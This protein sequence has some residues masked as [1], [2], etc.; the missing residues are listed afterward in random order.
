MAYTELTV[1]LVAA[2]V[3]MLGAII[4]TAIYRRGW[5]EVMD[6]FLPDL[7]GQGVR[8]EIAALI[9]HPMFWIVSVA[10]VAFFTVSLLFSINLAS[11]GYEWLAFSFTVVIFFALF[12]PLVIWFSE[13]KYHEPLRFVFGAMSYGAVCALLAFFINSIAGIFLNAQFGE[14][15]GLLLLITAAPLIEEA[16]KMLGVVLISAHKSFKGPLDGLLVGFA[17]GTGFAMMEN[18]FYT[19]TKIPENSLELLMFRALYNTLAHGAFTAIGG[20]VLGKIKQ[21]FK[22]PAAVQLG[23][24]FLVAALTHTAFNILAIVDIIGV[25]SLVLQYYIFSPLMVFAL[26]LIIA[27]LI[28]YNWVD[29]RRRI[30]REL[31]SLGVSPDFDKELEKLRESMNKKTKK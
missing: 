7:H 8:G 11:V 13:G 31:E 26:M 1:W 4:Y 27:L 23:V 9:I 3:V 28:F 19:A 12:D 6:L 2:M 30:A 15:M 22:V 29:K 16:L 5:L 14:K 18:I 17:A 21:D 25:N 10:V 20:A 24:P